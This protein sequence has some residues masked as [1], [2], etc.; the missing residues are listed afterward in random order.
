VP[1]ELFPA[2]ARTRKTLF[3]WMCVCA[4]FLVGGGRQEVLATPQN[5][6]IAQRG[7]SQ[8]IVVPMVAERWDGSSAPSFATKKRAVSFIGHLPS[9]E[10]AKHRAN[11]RARFNLQ[12]NS[13]KSRPAAEAQAPTNSGIVFDG[14]SESDTPFI[15][16]DAQIAAGPQ[17]LVVAIN[18]LLAIYDKECERVIFRTS[19]HFLVASVLR[20][21][22]SIRASSTTK[23]TTGS[24]CPQRK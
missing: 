18:S 23:A 1:I 24:F 2:S 4:M 5:S 6:E 20:G 13:G 21:R 3:L 12:D 9:Y 15:P 8:T 14:P 22:Y 7:Q 10:Q 19:T 17:Y 11:I 16:P